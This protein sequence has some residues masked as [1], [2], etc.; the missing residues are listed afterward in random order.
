MPEEAKKRFEE[1][2]CEVTGG[3][4]SFWCERTKFAADRNRV[5]TAPQHDTTLEGRLLV[6]AQIQI[7]VVIDAVAHIADNG[8]K[9]GGVV[10]LQRR[11]E[12]SSSGFVLDVGHHQADAIA[13]LTC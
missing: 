6:E 5:I 12:R 8:V 7:E 13:M 9:A 1:S 3:N 2:Y 4:I 10:A 11:K